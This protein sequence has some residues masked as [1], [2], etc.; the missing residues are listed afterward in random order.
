[1][2]RVDRGRARGP[3][4][5]GIFPTRV[6]VDRM[7]WFGGGAGGAL[8]L[9]VTWLGDGAHFSPSLLPASCV[10]YNPLDKN[11]SWLHNASTAGCISVQF[12]KTPGTK[13]RMWPS[14]PSGTLYR[15]SL[16]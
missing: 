10:E 4:P 11:S 14:E 12:D 15:T 2:G 9:G 13:A 16:V 1:M 8:R 5:T 6:W 3:A 7:T